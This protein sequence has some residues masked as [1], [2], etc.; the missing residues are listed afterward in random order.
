LQRRRRQSTQFIK[1]KNLSASTAY[2]YPTKQASGFNWKRF[3]TWAIIILAMISV[4]YYF[5]FGLPEPAGKEIIADEPITDFKEEAVI[6][7][8]QVTETPS[9]PFEDNIQVE[10]LNGCGFNGVAKIFQTYLREN[11]FDVVNTDNYVEDGKKRWDVK[12]SMVIDRIGQIEQAM[13]VARVLDI[14]SERVFSRENNESIYD[15]SV[16]IG[17]DFK[18]LNGSN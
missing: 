9:A 8:P 4:S 11:G 18:S 10:V 16:V 17:K 14:P 3:L 15:V 13:A 5:Y 12:K 7:E 1:K 6:E 2:S